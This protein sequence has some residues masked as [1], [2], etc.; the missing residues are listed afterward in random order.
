MLVYVLSD[1]HLSSNDEVPSWIIEEIK[2]ADLILINGDI[3]SK[4]ILDEISSYSKCLAV[5]GNCDSL[6]LPKTNVFEIEGVKCG[7][8][9][10][11]VVSP[12]GDWDQ[13][14]S[15]AVSLNINILFSGHTHCFSVYEYK[16]KLFINPGSAT[17]TTS[18]ISDR[19]VGT[20]AVI[21]FS[22]SEINV[23]IISKEKQLIDLTFD[24]KRFI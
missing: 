21:Y 6:N 13:L 2:N 22:N 8:V 24:K 17:G 5:Q 18:I 16:N 1:L 9:H 20:I 14:Y 7:Q 12:R 23:K 19:K 3:T 10:G 15:I 11:D 4:K